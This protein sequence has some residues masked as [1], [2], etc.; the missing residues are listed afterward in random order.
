MPYWSLGKNNLKVLGILGNFDVAGNMY[1]LRKT[2]YVLDLNNEINSKLERSTDISG[3]ATILPYYSGL[4]IRMLGYTATDIRNA[5]YEIITITR[6]VV[7]NVFFS[8][9]RKA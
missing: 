5:M 2:K 6:K 8:G 4:L 7:L 9:I 1:I 3:G